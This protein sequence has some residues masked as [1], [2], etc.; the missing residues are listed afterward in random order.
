MSRRFFSLKDFPL[1]Q[2]QKQIINKKSNLILSGV[3]GTGKTTL[4]F[5]I[6]L[7]D[8]KSKD[9]SKII[10][11]R[12]AVQVRNIGFLPGDLNE[13]IQEFELPYKSIIENLVKGKSYQQMKDDGWIEFIVSSFLRGI[14]IDDSVVIVDEFQNMNEHEILTVLTRI[15]ATSKLIFCGDSSQSDLLKSEKKE[16]ERI[17][18]V[19]K[20][21]D[22]FSHFEFG[23]NDIHRSDLLKE[24]FEKQMEMET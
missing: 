15:G 16:H 13:K 7:Q 5:R 18:N 22:S 21:M 19:L 2:K 1:S 23:V 20:K 10:V 11:I 4:A 14:T 9:F 6:A 24:F 3:A 8:L 17:M 12:S